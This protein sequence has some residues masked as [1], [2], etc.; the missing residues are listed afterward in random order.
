M[1]DHL[2]TN[3]HPRSQL[4]VRHV[5]LG[6]DRLWFDTGDLLQ[7]QIGGNGLCRVQLGVLDETVECD[8][9]DSWNVVRGSWL[10]GWRGDDLTLWFP[11]RSVQVVWGGH[12]PLPPLVSVETGLAMT[13]VDEQHVGRNGVVV[14]VGE[15]VGVG[16]H[17][18]EFRRADVVGGHFKLWKTRG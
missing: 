2:G 17:R 10:D 5:G 16:D 12:I 13:V 11:E 4:P 3:L 6:E 1:E 14:V 9:L 15:S 18:L 7:L 8:A